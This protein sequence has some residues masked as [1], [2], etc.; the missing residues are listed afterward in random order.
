MRSPF[1]FEDVAMLQ[2]GWWG[3]IISPLDIA[4]AAL[5]GML[6]AL[7]IHGVV[8]LWRSPGSRTLS[9]AGSASSAIPALLAGSAYCAPSLLLLLGAPVWAG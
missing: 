5:L 3:V 9:T 8:A 4:L 2:A 7:N 1:L 6:R